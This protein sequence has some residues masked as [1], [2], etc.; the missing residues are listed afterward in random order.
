LAAQHP[1]THRCCEAWT[2]ST[3]P[4]YYP[5]KNSTQ[6]EL[7]ALVTYDRRLSAAVSEAGVTVASPG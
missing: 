3:S 6:E 4:Q 7:D 5:W 1:W 2:P